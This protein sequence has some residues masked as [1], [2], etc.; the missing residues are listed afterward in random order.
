[1]V[2][3][4]TWTNFFVM[5]LVN[6]RVVRRSNALLHDAYGPDFHYNEYAQA[7]GSLSH[8]HLLTLSLFLCCSAID[9]ALTSLLACLH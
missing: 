6:T 3:S 2:P 4:R 8:T 7:K 9:L 1:M 5:A